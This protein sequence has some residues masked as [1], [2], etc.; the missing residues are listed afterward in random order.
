M[1]YQA[2]KQYDS[3]PHPVRQAMLPGA[4][5]LIAFFGFAFAFAPLPSAFAQSDLF[6]E[7]VNQ[8]FTTKIQPGLLGAV[9]DPDTSVYDFQ[10]MCKRLGVYGTPE[11]VP[12]VA[13]K[14]G[15]PEKCQAARN[16]LEEM[17][18]EE[19]LAALRNSVGMLDDPVLK[20]GVIDSLGMRRD[21]K[22]VDI[23]LP[24]LDSP[25]PL[26]ADAAMF[27]LARIADPS[28]IDRMVALG[29]KDAK[30]AHLALMYG[31]FLRRNECEPEALKVFRALAENA[32]APYFKEAAIFQILL[33]ET[34]DSVMETY[35]CIVDGDDSACR[36]A[37]RAA[38][39]VKSDAMCETLAKAF[40]A[41]PE[42]RKAAIV[43]GLGDQGGSVAQPVLLKAI[44]SE[45]P[46]VQ[47]A[48]AKAFKSFSTPEGMEKM[49]DA[50]LA[51][52]DVLKAQ[53][54]AAIR[55]FDSGVDP[56]ILALLD[57][58][59]E[60]Q[61]IGAELAGAHKIAAARPKLL[62]LAHS[63]D[64]GVGAA[65]MAALGS[66]A[67]LGVFKF[68]ADDYAA[69]GTEAALDGLR[70]ACGAIRGKSDAAAVLAEKADELK[71]NP[72][73]RKGI[74]EAFVALGC[75]AARMAV[76][77]A[78]NASDTESRDLATQALGQ[79]MTTD[80]APVLL[81]LANTPGYPYASRAIRGALRLAK[82]FAMPEWY[83]AGI[84]RDALAA[85]SCGPR[86]RELA[87]A[88]VKQYK[89]DL[90]VPETEGQKALREI[91]IVEA[92]Y[93]VQDGSAWNVTRDLRDAFLEASTTTLKMDEEYNSFFGGD[94]AP[95]CSKVLRVTVRLRDG[96]VKTV[97]FKENVPVAL[98]AE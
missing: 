87:D 96:S 49:I 90:S 98:P 2:G 82:Q 63:D 29:A 5:I 43:A 47:A 52:S 85:S 84:V 79:W 78:A 17:P 35:A 91:E 13:S 50:A 27:A 25:E 40:D 26:V 20:A 15:D 37:L 36:A 10:L 21:A 68:L 94:P 62:E 1:N 60:R 89:L 56:A 67:D 28:Y 23:L 71:G 93:G 33:K 97:E 34:S 51:G 38:Q 9:A 24:L 77:K 74:F 88:I 92:M 70:R 75:P 7:A 22:A 44:G 45:N 54:V 53:T 18:F 6:G 61:K 72:D 65:A 57:R 19:A 76:E 80:A 12:A 16:A 81:K 64:S 55:N 46:E 48:A 32:P 86:E 95:K 3:A 4:F 42:S 59:P 69:S 83:R 31:E 14:L 39:Y 73:R 66:I 41:A 58:D 8:D 30:C 11:A